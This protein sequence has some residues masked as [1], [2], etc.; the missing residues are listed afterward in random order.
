MPIPYGVVSPE[1]LAVLDC[2]P[3]TLFVL[4]DE[5]VNGIGGLKP[6]REFIR[7]ERG[8]KQNKFKYCNHLIVWKCMERSITRGGNTVSVAVRKINRVYG[9][10]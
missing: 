8:L 1:E 10:I 6:A 5:Y 9:T 4:W 7:C 3:K 2:C